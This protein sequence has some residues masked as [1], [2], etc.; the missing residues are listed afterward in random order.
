MDSFKR[1]LSV[2]ENVVS[3]GLRASV[4]FFETTRENLAIT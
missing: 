1:V 2:V 3:T 4:I